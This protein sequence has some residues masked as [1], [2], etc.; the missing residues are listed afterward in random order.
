LLKRRQEAANLA[1]EKAALLSEALGYYVPVELPLFAMRPG[2]LRFEQA[3]ADA[4]P[5]GRKALRQ[6]QDTF[7]GRAEALLNRT[8]GFWLPEDVAELKRAKAEWRQVVTEGGV[9]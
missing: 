5:E 4:S 2:D 8:H 9:Q 7:W 1:R 6:A 3:I